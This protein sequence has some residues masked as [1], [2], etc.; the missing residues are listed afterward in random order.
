MITN[1]VIVEIDANLQFD[2]SVAISKI[3]ICMILFQIKRVSL[4]I[5]ITIKFVENEQIVIF[6]LYQLINV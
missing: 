5:E 4:S 6:F 1:N 3:G 2:F